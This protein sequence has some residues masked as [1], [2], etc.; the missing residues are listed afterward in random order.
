ME[1]LVPNEIRNWYDN[2]ISFV[3]RNTQSFELFG[4]PSF[5]IEKFRKTQDNEYMEYMT[6]YFYCTDRNVLPDI[7]IKKHTKFDFLFNNID[8]Y[9][10]NINLKKYLTINKHESLYYAT[11]HNI[12]WF[13]TKSKSMQI[14]TFKL[15]PFRKYTAFD[16]PLSSYIISENVMYGNHCLNCMCVLQ[17]KLLYISCDG[18]IKI[19]DI[20]GNPL[21]EINKLHY[22]QNNESVNKYH[23]FLQ[24]YPYDNNHIC[25]IINFDNEDEAGI[26]LYNIHDGSRRSDIIFTK[27][28]IFHNH[29]CIVHIMKNYIKNNII[30]DAHTN[31]VC[32]RIIQFG[33]AELNEI[34]YK[35]ITLQQSFKNMTLYCPNIPCSVNVNAH[36]C[37]VFYPWTFIANDSAMMT[38]RSECIFERIKKSRK[39]IDTKYELLIVLPTYWF[40]ENDIMEGIYEEDNNERFIIIDCFTKMWAHHKFLQESI[41]DLS[42]ELFSY[43]PE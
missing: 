18:S 28:N 43:F 36:F 22:I 27:S 25:A 38:I 31:E 1:Y 33:A 41:D 26:V 24:L 16:L 40:K 12:L 35:Q 34:T 2:Y 32:A 30:N 19:L 37:K 29:L 3:L 9:K 20:Y 14:T 4:S 8:R 10:T 6:K 13:F 42:F 5:D 23:N 7:D 11:S 39:E 17:D 21:T 15:F